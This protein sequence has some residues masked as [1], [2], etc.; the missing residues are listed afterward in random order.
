MQ[1][2]DVV[3][4][5]K[6]VQ[7]IANEHPDFTY[8]SNTSVCS[9]RPDDRNLKGCL[10][11][12]ALT[13]IGVDINAMPW[14]ENPTIEEALKQLEFPTSLHTRWLAYVQESQDTGYS[15]KLAVQIADKQILEEDSL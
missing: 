12:A 11:G 14:A 6:A 4:L 8:R 5:T 3:E 13:Q 9:Y 10:I 2:F 1:T 7:K 15:W